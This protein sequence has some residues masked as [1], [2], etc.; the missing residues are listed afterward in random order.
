[1]RRCRRSLRLWH[2]G[3]HSPHS[4]GHQPLEVKD[5]T[6]SSKMPQAL[7]QEGPV[8]HGPHTRAALQ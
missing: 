5:P 3:Y 8:G 6:K 1:M 7:Q 2:M 4:I